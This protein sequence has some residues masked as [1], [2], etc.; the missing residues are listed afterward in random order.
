MGLNDFYVFYQVVRHCRNRTNISVEYRTTPGCVIVF[1]V[2]HH[3]AVLANT[4]LGEVVLPLCDLRELSAAQTVDDLPAV[5]V[6]LQRPK[7]PRYGP[8][9]VGKAV[10]VV[11]CTTAVGFSV[12]MIITSAA[13]QC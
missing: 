5:M 13:I 9:K 3:E 7:E 10:S 2:W 11:C 12:K 1:S 6:K 4:F 8:Y